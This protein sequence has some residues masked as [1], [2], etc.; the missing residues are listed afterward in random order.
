MIWKD[1]KSRISSILLSE[2]AQN[3]NMNCNDE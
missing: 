3:E 1:S 2:F